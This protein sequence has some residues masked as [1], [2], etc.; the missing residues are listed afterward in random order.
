MHAF[1]YATKIAGW[2]ASL[3]TKAFHLGHTPQLSTLNYSSLAH[4]L[5]RQV[6]KLS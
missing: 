5:I 2:M 1:P 6:P 3:Q 4:L